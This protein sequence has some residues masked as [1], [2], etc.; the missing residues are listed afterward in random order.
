MRVRGEYLEYLGSKKNIAII[1][2]FEFE[3][4]KINTD[5][6]FIQT[7][8]YRQLH[9]NSELKVEYAFNRKFTTG[10]GTRYE[11]IHFKPINKY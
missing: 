11:W 3:S 8:A 2:K 7:G 5:S 10:V 1:P 6:N 4:I 9:A